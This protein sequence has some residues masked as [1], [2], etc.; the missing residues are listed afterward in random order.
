MDGEMDMAPKKRRAGAG[1]SV[2][3][4]EAA[5]YYQPRTRQTRDA[6]EALL[7]TIQTLFGDQPH[8][9]LRGAAD[10]VLAVL[11]NDRLKVR[12]SFTP[13]ESIYTRPLRYVGT[14]N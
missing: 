4:L 9:V 11:K 1:P 12:C 2:M 14:I 3:D 10:E 6:Y 5:G 13:V 7:D 8:D